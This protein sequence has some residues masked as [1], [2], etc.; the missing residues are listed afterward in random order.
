[1]KIKHGGHRHPPHHPCHR[2]STPRGVQG[3]DAEGRA[4]VC[5]RA[6][7]DGGGHGRVPDEARRRPDPGEAREE[8]R[9]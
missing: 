4:G 5:R 7:T 6:R 3:G 2:G 8:G 9:N 1:M